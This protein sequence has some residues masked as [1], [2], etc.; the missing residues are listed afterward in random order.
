LIVPD[1]RI[2]GSHVISDVNKLAMAW[3]TE[4]AGERLGTKW[5]DGETTLE[6]SEKWPVSESVRLTVR[7]I[8]TEAFGRA[9][10]I[11][12]LTES[13]RAASGFTKEQARI[14]AETEANFAMCYGNLAAWKKTGMVK[15]VKWFKSMLHTERDSCDLN[16][17]AGAIP[18][19]QLFPSGDPAPP[20][21][22]GCR[23]GLGIAEL[24]EPK[25]KAV[26]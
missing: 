13:I 26:P 19:G 16:V 24:I 7:Q 14:V 20:V 12:E 8:V 2:Q 15:S 5:Y 3:A 18:I 11:S 9:T 4:H 21:H 10:P 1:E 25:R 22:I 23:C 6:P 17:E